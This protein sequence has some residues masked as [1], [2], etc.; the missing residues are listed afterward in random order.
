MM[1][2]LRFSIVIPYRQRLAN[3]RL[4]FESLAEQTLDQARFEV[5]VGVLEYSSEYVSLCQ[6]FSE[7][8]DV[9]SVL[10]GRPWQVGLARNLALRQTRGEVLLLLDAD[11]VLPP[12]LLQTL[13]ERHFAYGQR[14]CVVGQM[15]DYNNNTS[16]VESVQVKGFDHYRELLAK[17]EAVGEVRE[18]PRLQCA[19]VIPWSFAWTA[20]IAV[21]AALVAEHELSFDLDF[22]G[23]GVEDL[24]WA[25]R[26]SATGTPI[27]VSADVY[28]IHLP[29][30]R[31]LAANQRT[32][33]INY[34]RFLRKWP[35]PD[36]ELASAFGDFE[37]NARYR[38][39][40][41]R[42]RE[43]AALDDGSLAVLFGVVDG[44]STL[45]V[46]AVVDRH[47][48]LVDRRLVSGFDVPPEVLPLTGLAL[49]WE[50][51]GVARARILPAVDRF[52]DPY[53]ERMLAEIRRVTSSVILTEPGR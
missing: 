16:D 22:H 17:L 13:Y 37:A 11:V 30:Q 46:G 24:E 27:T 43:A 25:H 8:L 48:Q 6:E 15:I 2:D 20:L 18:D 35:G 42:I 53:Q 47:G 41:A 31:S 45:V 4:V 21:P 10:S 23:Y 29:H 5:V 33:S 32:E 49:P 3:L 1:S 19:H 34:R 12:N 26:V 50:D 36:V 9:V 40:T 38:D 44:V 28:G 39:F 51:D 14:V 52:A 7:R